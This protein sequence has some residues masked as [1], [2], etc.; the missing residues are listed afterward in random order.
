MCLLVAV[1]LIS[2][3]LQALLL[4]AVLF[5][6]AQAPLDMF[7]DFLFLDVISAPSSDEYKL[8]LHNPQ[9][10]QNIGGQ[11]VSIPAPVSSTFDSIFQCLIRGSNSVTPILPVSHSGTESNLG[12]IQRHMP[13]RRRLSSV[14]LKKFTVPGIITRK[15]PPSFVQLHSFTSLILKDV[16]VPKPLEFETTRRNSCV[17]PEHMS[18]L[19]ATDEDEYMRRSLYDSVEKGGMDKNSDTAASF[20][21]FC[22]M[23][24]KQNDLL[25]GPAKKEFQSRWGVNFDYDD[26]YESNTAIFGVSDHEIASGMSSN[27]KFKLPC[28]KTLRK[29][30]RDI[31]SE[32]I[33]ETCQYS[34]EKY[35]KLKVV[36]NVQKG[37]E[38]MHLFIIDLL[39]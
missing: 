37:L 35:G 23:L 18:V 15:L 19:L 33:K 28:R 1:I 17:N 38:I 22:A 27:L 11:D 9:S 14:M 3:L 21:S 13:T 39:G 4:I 10:G 2:L 16:F 25:N 5:A 20:E 24:H 32:A 31:L 30:Q 7:V 8:S 26:N 34:S 12:Q 36:S 29:S 6:C